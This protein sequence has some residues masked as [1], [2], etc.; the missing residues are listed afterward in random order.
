MQ[1]VLAPIVR[2]QTKMMTNNEVFMKIKA[3]YKGNTLWKVLYC[4]QEMKKMYFLS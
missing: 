1:G 3:Y 2:G 4:P